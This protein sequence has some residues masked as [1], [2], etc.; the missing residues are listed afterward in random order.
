[1]LRSPKTKTY[2]GLT[3]TPDILNL[4]K[5]MGHEYDEDLATSTGRKGLAALFAT[6]LFGTSEVDDERRMLLI[7][8]NGRNLPIN[9]NLT[10]DPIRS[11]IVYAADERFISGRFRVVEPARENP[12]VPGLWEATVEQVGE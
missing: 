11:P 9:Q 8:I 1:M 2:R 12:D 3:V 4:F 5:E 6:D 10:V 7:T